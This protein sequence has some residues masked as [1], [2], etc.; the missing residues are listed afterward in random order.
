LRLGL[1]GAIEYA[2]KGILRDLDCA[3]VLHPLLAFSLFLE[4]L[5]FSGDVTAAEFRGDIFP[6][7]FD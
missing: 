5:N 1:V 6:E 2:H 7:M 4:H 3:D